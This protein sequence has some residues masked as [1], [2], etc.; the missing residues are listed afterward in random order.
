[1]KDLRS[2]S[3][4][5]TIVAVRRDW[6]TPSARCGVDRIFICFSVNRVT[7]AIRFSHI[8]KMPLTRRINARNDSSLGKTASDRNF[9]VSTK[10]KINNFCIN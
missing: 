7:S 10:I 5:R 4:T 8:I 6:L 3:D 2:I 1:L 9:D